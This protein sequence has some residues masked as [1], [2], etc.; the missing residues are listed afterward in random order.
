MPR[1]TKRTMYQTP[2]LV[3][4]YTVVKDDE[5]VLETHDFAEALRLRRDCAG[6]L[7]AETRDM[8]PGR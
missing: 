7:V 5:R 4:I 1:T 2:T 3:N 8:T 6:E